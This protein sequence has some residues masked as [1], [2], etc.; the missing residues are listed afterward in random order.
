[1]SKP[2]ITVHIQSATGALRSI[3][4]RIGRSL[5][6]AAVDA[7]IDGIAADC[8]GCLSCATCH[9]FVGE[10]WRAK[11]PPASSDEAAMLEM[12]AVPHE[13]GSRLSCQIELVSTLDGL[14]VRL[15]SNQ[16]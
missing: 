15:P 10:A 12:T 13:T 1:M 9:V 8:G 4:G 11:L 7:G 2:S 16:Y 3:Q 6:Q 14:E 5:M